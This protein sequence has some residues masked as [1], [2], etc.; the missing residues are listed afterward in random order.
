G[1]HGLATL[2]VDTPD[3]FERHIDLKRQ[4]DLGVRTFI[5][6]IS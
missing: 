1:I 3:L 4:V 6:G 2:R 5:A